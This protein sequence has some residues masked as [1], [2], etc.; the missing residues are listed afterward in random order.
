[1][2]DRPCM[3]ITGTSRGLGKDLALHYL[4]SYRVIGVNRTPSSIKSDHYEE[5][6]CDLQEPE[7]ISQAF[8]AIASRHKKISVLINN[9]A[10][11][12]STPL[13]LMSATD[14]VQMVQTNLTSVILCSKSVLHTMMRARQGSIINISSMATKVLIPGDT[15]YAATK[16]GIDTFAKVLNEEVAR[17][18]IRVNTVAVSAYD[19]GMLQQ[20]LN[21]SPE[22]VTQHIP[23]GN[24][25]T[26]LDIQNAIDFFLRPQSRDIGGQIVYLGGI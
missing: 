15:V 21:E 18:G 5:E 2:A 6:L 17:Y 25:A 24:L 11:L 23:H 9:A 1:V 7:S 19:T 14:I 16:A 8:K 22:K 10:V 20:I 3:V 4:N 13:A 26:F 12:K